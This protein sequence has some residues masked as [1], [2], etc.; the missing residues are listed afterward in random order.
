LGLGNARPEGEGHVDSESDEFRCAKIAFR[1][2][3]GSRFIDRMINRC[4][5]PALSVAVISI[6][7]V[8]I[9]VNAPIENLPSLKPTRGLP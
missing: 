5:S 7:N 4:M 9:N 1:A 6:S 3:N 2:V 8:S